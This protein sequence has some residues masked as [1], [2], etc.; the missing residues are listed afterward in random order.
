MATPEMTPLGKDSVI[1]YGMHFAT[2]SEKELKPGEHRE[3]RVDLGTLFILK[4]GK[5][6]VS[7]KLKL[8]QPALGER[9]PFEIST[10]PL[11]FTEE[12]IQ[13]SKTNQ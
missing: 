2:P 3:W 8:S 7:V 1:D 5:Y 13:A 6:L 4:P 10:E 9:V 11:G 12:I